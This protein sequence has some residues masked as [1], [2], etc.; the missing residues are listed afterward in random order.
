MANV[1]QENFNTSPS[2]IRRLDEIRDK[3]ERLDN[4]FNKL[5]ERYNQSKQVV[6]NLCNTSTTAVTQRQVPLSVADMN[7]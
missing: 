2:K 6:D 1:S 7:K 5:L 4:E 3:E